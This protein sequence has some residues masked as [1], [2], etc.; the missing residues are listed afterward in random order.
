[1]GVL[2]AIRPASVMLALAAPVATTAQSVP[3]AGVPVYAVTA[4]FGNVMG[5]LGVAGEYFVADG[6]MSVM[7][8]AGWLPLDQAEG[9]LPLGF[10]GALRG[11]LGASRHRALIEASFSLVS[12]EGTSLGP[13]TIESR[14]HYG[15]G[16]AAG[17]RLTTTSGFHFEVS[18]GSG[19]SVD[20]DT[21]APVGSLAVGYTW[22]R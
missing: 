3:D 1:M 7:G 17:Y 18:A 5:W 10:G 11:Y 8:G 9:S 20:D 2:H 6:H 14:Q 4:G 22:R 21:I 15:V 13:V 19:W 12:V 16:V